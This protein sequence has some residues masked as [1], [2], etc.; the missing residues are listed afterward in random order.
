MSVSF[1]PVLG[2]S[3]AVVDEEG[4]VKMNFELRFQNLVQMR[5]V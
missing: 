1:I 5:L 4:V 3:V 2:G